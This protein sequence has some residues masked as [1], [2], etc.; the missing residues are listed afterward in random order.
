MR[1]TEVATDSWTKQIDTNTLWKQLKST[2]YRMSIAKHRIDDIFDE[3]LD[4]LTWKELGK[5]NHHN[6]FSLAASSNGERVEKIDDRL[7]TYDPTTG[8]VIEF[9]GMTDY[10]IPLFLKYAKVY[11][12]YNALCKG[13]RVELENREE[14]EKK[15]HRKTFGKSRRSGR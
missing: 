15:L 11:N 3:E 12:R 4:G 14:Q 5:S 6:L 7:V 8:T 13:I 2:E 1:L 9:I 10:Y